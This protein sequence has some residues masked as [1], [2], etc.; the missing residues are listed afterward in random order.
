MC[1]CIHS[2]IRGKLHEAKDYAY[3]GPHYT[4]NTKYPVVANKLSFAGCPALESAT[5]G[6]GASNIPRNVSKCMDPSWSQ[7]ALEK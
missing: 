3:L 4:P 6:S 5:A 1:V 2:T 7:L